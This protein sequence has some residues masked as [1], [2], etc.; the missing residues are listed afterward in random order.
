MHF[1]TCVHVSH[2]ET[3]NF[4]LSPSCPQKEAS[5]ITSSTSTPSTTHFLPCLVPRVLEKVALPR[6]LQQGQWWWRGKSCWSGHQQVTAHQLVGLSCWSY[7]TPGVEKLTPGLHLFQSLPEHTGHRDT[8]QCER[9]GT[10]WYYFCSGDCST[11]QVS[12]YLPLLSYLA[13]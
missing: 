9:L 8:S 1:C 10:A 7:T 6:L 4:N 3:P 11:A 12:M 2:I 5:S 13:I